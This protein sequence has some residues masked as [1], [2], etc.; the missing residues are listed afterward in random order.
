MYLRCKRIDSS[1]KVFFSIFNHVLVTWS[2]LI[3]GYSQCGEYKK[4]FLFFKKLNT[5]SKNS[6]FV[7]IASVLASIA[8]T[9]KGVPGC[10][11][12]GYVLWHGLESHVNVSSALIYM[13]SKCGFSGKLCVQYDA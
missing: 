1:Y 13:Y 8:Q 2:T 7:L 6:N 12:H 10:E 3:V 5:K 9:M 4:S 11:L